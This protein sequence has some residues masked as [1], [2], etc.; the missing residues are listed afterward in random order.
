LETLVPRRVI[1]RVVGQPRLPSRNSRIPDQNLP[2][3]PDEGSEE[4]GRGRSV[5]PKETFVAQTGA[6]R[7]RSP[8]PRPPTKG[9]S[10]SG[11]SSGEV[12]PDHRTKT[13]KISGQSSPQSGVEQISPPWSSGQKYPTADQKLEA[14]LAKASR[15]SSVKSPGAISPRQ[16]VELS[17]M[18]RAR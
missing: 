18:P 14:M 17:S 9:Q 7:S 3:I 2:R 5:L 10:I 11:R 6:N 1:Q 15:P 4:G 12:T 8:T 16:T 13:S